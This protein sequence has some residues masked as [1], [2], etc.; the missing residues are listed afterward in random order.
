[1]TE[2]THADEG[3]R[4]MIESTR[5]DEGELCMT[6]STHADEGERCITESTHANEGERWTEEYPDVTPR[7]PAHV[8]RE[9]SVVLS[10][11]DSSY[12]HR[13]NAC[14]NNTPLLI[15]TSTC[16]MNEMT[17]TVLPYRHSDSGCDITAV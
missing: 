8:L 11:D 14:T 5:A 4:C 13:R 7:Y 17:H 3:E 12:Y 15:H 16:S 6:E 1:M 2:S 9:V 10:A